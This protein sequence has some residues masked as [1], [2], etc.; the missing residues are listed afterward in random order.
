MEKTL[1]TKNHLIISII[2]YGGN[3]ILFLFYLQELFSNL[4]LIK[5]LTQL[6]YYA[7]SIYLFL[8]LICDIFLYLNNN[9][10]EE[11]NYQLL[12]EQNDNYSLEWYHKLNDWNRNKYGI[13]CNTFSFFVSISFWILFFLGETYIRVS[14][15]F[16]AMLSTIN[17]HLII[18]ILIIVDIFNSK[19]DH[20]FSYV[21]FGIISL[22][23]L[24]YIAFT[25]IGKYYFNINPY[26]FM[27]GS[28]LFLIFYVSIS[29]CLL[30]V[31]Y[32]L[33]V[34]LINYK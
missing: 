10:N 5:Y 23:F 25:G 7:N 20:K 8:C 14:N 21:Y 22:I 11:N 28:L 32:L 24:I 4:Y 6:S 12:E 18:S 16:Y 26:E 1:I 27:N 30:Y 15:T 2:L 9:L 19:K 29:F 17:L 13:I 33:N 34:Y 31:S 3:T